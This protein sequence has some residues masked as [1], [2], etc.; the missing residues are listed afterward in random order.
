ML[1]SNRGLFDETGA[2]MP[3]SP[4]PPRAG[5]SCARRPGRK[6]M[7]G[8]RK[9]VSGVNRHFGQ[10]ATI[11]DQFLE[12]CQ[13]SQTG[14]TTPSVVDLAIAIDTY[15][16]GA[17]RARDASRRVNQFYGQRSVWKPC[18]EIPRKNLRSK[19][20]AVREPRSSL[21]VELLHSS[22]YLSASPLL[23]AFVKSCLLVC[24][25][26]RFRKTVTPMSQDNEL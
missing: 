5:A 18:F 1:R 23:R 26:E 13:Q 22:L 15:L 8:D 6:H 19:K 4:I 11:S 16:G 25:I 2:F 21:G 12:S 7:I 3:N 14:A 24:R 17:S 20:L 9:H 10:Q